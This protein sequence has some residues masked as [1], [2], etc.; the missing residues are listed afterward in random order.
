MMA[1][2][3]CFHSSQKDIANLP[4]RYNVAWIVLADDSNSK[5]AFLQIREEDK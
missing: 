3:E 1:R 4:G 5:S 2:E